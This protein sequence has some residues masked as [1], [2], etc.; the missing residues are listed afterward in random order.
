MSKFIVEHVTVSH[1]SD[2]TPRLMSLHIPIDGKIRVHIVRPN[3]AMFNSIINKLGLSQPI[4][5]VAEFVTLECPQYYALIE[6]AG[7]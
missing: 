1:N 7:K 4:E 5:I 2:G 3:T 6:E